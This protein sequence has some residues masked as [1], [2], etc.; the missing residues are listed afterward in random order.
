M[1]RRPQAK[2]SSTPASGR[3]GLVVVF[4]AFLLLSTASCTRR[5]E[6]TPYLMGDQSE[7]A[8]GETATL[9]CSDQCR[10]SSQCGKLN[11]EQVILASS[12]GPAMADHDLLFPHGLTVTVAGRETRLLENV[13]DASRSQQLDFYAVVTADGRAGWVAGWCIGRPVVP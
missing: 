4:L 2:P 5:K 3:V 10:G 6:E 8:L 9:V 7:L 1:D 13:S 12:R 11:S